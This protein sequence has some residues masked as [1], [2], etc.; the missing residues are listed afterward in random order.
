MSKTLAIESGAIIESIKGEY[1]VP[2]DIPSPL[3]LE[4]F[5]IVKGKIQLNPKFKQLTNSEID[6]VLQA[7]MQSEQI[8][9]AKEAILRS[10]W[11]LLS[12]KQMAAKKVLRGKPNI[13]D[14]DFLNLLRVDQ[15]RRENAL[16]KLDVFELQSVIAKVSQEEF[17][18]RI[19]NKGKE[20]DQEMA[21]LDDKVEGVRQKLEHDVAN[22]TTMSDLSKINIKIK[23][24][25]ELH[26][27][28]SVS[29]IAAILSS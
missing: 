25:D 11:T 13:K 2:P 18:N 21:T 4:R 1:I 16:K 5:T 26:V 20:W 29:E 9:Q 6:T 17:R 3:R 27:T 22:A 14:H 10:I 19:L 8:N 28:A 23:G 12:E 24:L 7:D 15:E